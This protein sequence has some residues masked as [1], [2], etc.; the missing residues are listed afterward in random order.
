MSD[1]SIFFPPWAIAWFLLGEA[2]PFITL[3]LICLTAAFFFNRS[4]RR[5]APVR[6]LNGL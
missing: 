1:I 2:T 6:W 5:T 3:V 4:T